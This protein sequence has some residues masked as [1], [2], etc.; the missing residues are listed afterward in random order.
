[1]KRK[2]ILIGLAVALA[3][4]ILAVIII[5][6]LPPRWHPTLEVKNTGT[7][8]VTLSYKG[9]NFLSQPGQTWKM[10]F[11]GGETLTLRAGEAVDAPSITVTLP[12]RNPK[13]WM[14]NPIV[15]IWTAE[16][17]ADDPKNIRVEN[18]RFEEVTSPR[19]ASE[20]W[21]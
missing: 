21:P 7:N 4:T 15:Q 18:R 11:Y 12:E 9:E 8:A 20:P 10:R 2:R 16:V 5:S 3:A 17:N 14:L 1:M 6:L 19:S 13:P